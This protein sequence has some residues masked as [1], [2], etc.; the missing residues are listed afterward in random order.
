MAAVERCHSTRKP[1]HLQYRMIARDGREVCVSDDAVI[2]PGGPGKGDLLLGVMTDITERKGAQ[3]AL[4]QSEQRFRSL[5]ETTSDWIWEVDRHGVYTY[6]SPKVRDLL[7]YAPEEVIGKT[8][9]DLMPPDEAERV[10]PLFRGILESRE[11][12]AGLENTNLHKDGRRVVLETSGVPIFDADGDLV[13]Y[14]GIDRDV[15]ERKTAED[16]L[17]AS[18]QRYR[19]LAD[20][21]TDV[22]WATD[23]DQ[24]ITYVSPSVRRLRGYTAEEAV[25][26]DFQD[27]L[28]PESARVGVAAFE[29]ALAHARAHP[30]REIEPWTVVSEAKCKDGS[31]IWIETTAALV[32]DPSG[33]P[34]GLEGVTRDISLRKRAEDALRKGE[35]KYRLLVDTM[36]EGVAIRDENS[37]VTYVN[38]RACEII[39]YE[40]E[41]VIGRK[42]EDFL[43]EGGRQT[44][45]AQSVGR[46]TGRADSYEIEFPRRDGRMVTALLSP[47]PM[48]D[49]SGQYVGSF[50]VL[51]DLTE[52]RRLERELLAAGSRLERRIGQNLHDSLGQV[53]TGVAFQAKALEQRLAALSL[54]EVEQAETIRSLVN[55]AISQT[56]SLARGL[57]PV[58]LED[59]GLMGALGMLANSTQSL[60]RVPCEFT[61]EDAVLISDNDVAAH[62]YYIAQEAV[63]NAVRHSGASR[64]TIEL[65]AGDGGIGLVVRDDGHGP[66]A[67]WEQ[68]S[69]L[70]L[71]IMRHRARMIGASLEIERGPTGGVTVSCL[72]ETDVDESHA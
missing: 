23:L 58:D 3:E 37:I 51:T 7:G 21:A 17:R 33:R 61:C 52:Y 60:Y 71:G 10:G 63:T 56:Q 64:I 47:G 70:G 40:R 45:A 54:R 15:T 36:G 44:M 46:E 24:R 11:S 2:L 19:L 41:E 31:T 39:G 67:G 59:Q 1:L 18:E 48:F 43:G 38:D 62:L 49:D 72:L 66:P 29:N 5:V 55:E 20:N 12:F 26:Q 53:L 13:G 22:I 30:D 28:T 65:N 57:M 68:G 16:A 14:R 4:R 34:T 50:A 69:G 8:P 9:F 35:A 25:G 6:A 42:A 27:T 32:Y